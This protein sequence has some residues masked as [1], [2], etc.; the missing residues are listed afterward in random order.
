MDTDELLTAEEVGKFLKVT[1]QWV[2]QR[3]AQGKIP[4]K[5][6]GGS[7]RFVKS[8]LI[9]WVKSGASAD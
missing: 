3:K 4:Y 5:K 6:I 7:I 9:E 2:Y 8:E 1:P